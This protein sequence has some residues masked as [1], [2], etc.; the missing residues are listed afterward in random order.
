LSPE[1]AKAGNI[2]I[3][4]LTTAF[5]LFQLGI[6]TGDLSSGV[7][8]QVAKTRKKTILAFMAI[9]LVGTSAFFHGFATGNTNYITCFIMGLG[10]GYLSVFVTTTAEQFGTNYRVLVTSTVT[11]FMRGSVTVLIP[12][13]A[14]LENHMT[15]WWSLVVTGM[16]VWILAITSTLLLRET[17]GRDLDFLD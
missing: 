9:A 2:S 15:L 6:T 4:K 1:L 8:S 13:R 14:M 7:I 16:I 3:W 17:Y 10:C 11:N 5:T 12:L